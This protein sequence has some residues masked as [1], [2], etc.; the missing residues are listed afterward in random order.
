M[1]TDNKNRHLTLEERQIIENGIKDGLKKSEIAT[2]L[3]KDKST[4]G[5][6]I[7]L[8]R[9][10][11]HSMKLKLECE[12][13]RKCGR[14]RNCTSDCP[15]YIPFVCSRRDRSPGACNG[16]D[17]YSRCRFNKYHYD[18]QHADKEYRSAL[19]DSRCGVNLTSSEAQQLADIVAPLLKQGHSPYQIVSD[20]PDLG[21]C[22]RTL[23]NY[24]DAGIFHYLGGVTNLDLRRK[25]GRKMPRKKKLQYR[26]RDSKAYLK[27]R[28][29]S[30]YSAFIEENSDVFVTQMDTVY[31]DES[32][33]PFVQTFKFMSAGVMIGI[34]HSKKTAENMTGGIDMLERILGRDVF[35]RYCSVILTDRGSEFSNADG[36][37]RSRDG[38]VRTRIFYCDPMRSNQKGSLENYHIELR[39]ILPKEK[40]LHELGL[41]CQ[42]ALNT[43]LSHIN[44]SSHKKLGGKSPLEAAE[45]MYPDLYEKLKEF[46]IVQIERNSIILN[47]S[48]LRNFRKEE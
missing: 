46:G 32:N 44:S 31:N 10:F 28:T 29:Y 25:V 8:H 5:K 17:R 42:D 13:Y 21:I 47:P 15:D 20:N 38:N 33:G 40:N 34:L 16:C 6:E 45:F 1:T 41:T 3:G 9:L 30:D 26:K 35:G 36:I 4:I 37:E 7:R 19:S 48:V 11:K 24:I 14:G 43:A 22:E 39:Y 12:G 27:G 23:Y 18:A 2:M